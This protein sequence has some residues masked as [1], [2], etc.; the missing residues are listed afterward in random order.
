MLTGQQRKQLNDAIVSAFP[1]KSA[2]EQMLSF[3]LNMSLNEIAGG[4]N[5]RDIVFKLIQT[6]EAEGWIEQFI[7]AAHSENPGNTNLKDVV[8]AL[9]LNSSAKTEDISSSSIFVA[10]NLPAVPQSQPR[11]IFPKELFDKFPSSSSQE[12]I[13]PNQFFATVDQASEQDCTFTTHR[14]NKYEQSQV[15]NFSNNSFV[16]DKKIFS[17]CLP[18]N[19]VATVEILEMDSRT[20]KEN[21][22]NIQNSGT[23]K[24][25]QEAI[26]KTCAWLKTYPNESYVRRQYLILVIEK[27]KLEQQQ[28]AIFNTSLW[29]KDSLQLCDGYVFTEY[30]KLV[31]KQGTP[32]QCREASSQ[33][34][35][36]LQRNPDQPYVRKQWLFLAKEKLQPDHCQQVISWTYSWLSDNLTTCDSYVMT[37][38][39]R[40]N[41]K[42][43]TS[44]QCQEAIVQ[45]DC[46]LQKNPDDSYVRTQYLALNKKLR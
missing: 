42:A 39:L 29:L 18:I 4:D 35:I 6:A 10:Q 17:T 40:L 27:G 8:E 15:D 23:P 44:H 43:G 22:V 37:E 7:T 5:L 46:W 24:Q 38:Y 45:A 1:T 25:C 26:A 11:S 28:E 14:V 13:L 34:S 30:L 21:L 32:E 31:A 2:L 12:V 36:W 3:K 16:E 20:L 33:A 19:E 9:L 41:N